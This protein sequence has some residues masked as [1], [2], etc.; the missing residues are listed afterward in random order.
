MR[1]PSISRRWLMRTVS[2]STLAGTVVGPARRARAA[3]PVQMISHRYPALEYYAG[4]MR[5]AV[6]GVEVNTQLM[7]QDKAVELATIALSSKSDTVD[8]VYANDSIFLVFAKNGWIRPLDDLWE[9]HRAEFGLDDFSS[10][11]MKNLSFNGHKYVV[12]VTGGVMLFFYRKDLFEKSGKQPPKTIAEYRDLAKSFNSAQRSG[13]ISCLKPIDAC[14]NEA[15]WYMNAIGDGWFDQQWKPIFNNDKGVA[16]IEM[17]TEM[18]RYAQQGFTSAA[19]DECTIALQQDAAAMGL[20]WATR[21]MSMDDP[22]KSR[23]VGKIDWVAP[24][25]GHERVVNDGYCISAFSKQDPDTLFRI[26]ATVTSA[27]NMREAAGL[28]LPP[29]GSLLGDEELRKKY[30]F[31]PAAIDALAVGQPYPG[32]PEFYSVGEFI[33]RRI[34]QAVTGEMG[35][36]KALD[37]AAG[38]TET[39]LKGHGY[40]K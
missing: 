33:T 7:P 18:T 2:A 27:Q 29:R 9:K 38:E 10:S 20:Q 14:L 17:M 6:P 32:L 39:F 1:G 8:I 31:Y 30:R 3:G 22:N 36:K 37:A 26:L 25:Q 40:Y 4:K 24:P 16:A 13:T 21:A 12:P 34:L 28:I 35:V 15:H 19:N 11:V 5:T 23:V